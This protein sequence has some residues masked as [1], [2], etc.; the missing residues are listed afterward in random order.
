M[1]ITV[2]RHEREKQELLGISNRLTEAILKCSAQGLF[3]LDGKDKILTP[4]S[5]SL[6]A[7]FRRQEFTNLSFEKLLAPIVTAKV[8]TTARNHIAAL[9]SGT[10]RDPAT[11]NPL[12]DIDVRLTN[13]D[14]SFDTAHYGFEFEPVF[15]PNEAR[16]WLVRVTDI[17]ARVQTTRELDDLRGQHQIQGEI[18]RGVLQ[19]GGARFGGFMQKAEASMKTIRPCSRSR[20]AKKT[21]FATSSMR[22]STK[23]IASGARR[24]RS[25]SPAWK[26]RRAFRGCAA[27]AAQS[28]RALRQRFPAARRE[29]GPVVQSICADQVA[30][31]CG[32]SGAPG[33]RIISWRADDEQRHADHR[34]PEVPP[35]KPRARRR[36][37]GAR[38]G[39]GGKPRQHPACADG[40]RGARTKQAGGAREHWPAIRTVRIPVGDQERRDSTH[41]QRRHARNRAAG[42]AQ[43]G[44]QT[45]SRHLAH[46]VQGS[47]A[48]FRIAVRG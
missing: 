9:L 28:Q 30:D 38:I 36:P 11:T 35:R 19:M 17:T 24:P 7:L 39:S 47:R 13:A 22:F 34:G 40:T 46:R 27:R 32:R 4:V 31:H 23:S 18:L 45:R 29:V 1:F 6:A 21:R 25:S 15:V 14:G 43:S 3:M 41:S 2:K 42:G 8:L 48:A 44:R 12:S 10:V 33:R 16:S 5:Q 20:R 26:A 37:Q